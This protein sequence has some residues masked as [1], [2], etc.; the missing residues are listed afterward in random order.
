MIGPQTLVYLADVVVKPR[1]VP[2][3]CRTVLRLLLTV[4][5]QIIHKLSTSIDPL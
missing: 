3:G 2:V 4:C 5:A 1:E